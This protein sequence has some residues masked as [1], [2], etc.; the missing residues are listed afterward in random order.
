[1]RDSIAGALQLKFVMVFLVIFIII[2][3]AGLRFLTAFRV[4]NQI[5]S[6]VEMYQGYC[7]DSSD[8]I[9]NPDKCPANVKAE[10]YARKSGFVKT[11][12]GNIKR[13]YLVEKVETGK[14]EDYYVVS[15][16]IVFGIPFANT[17]FTIRV[18]GQTNG[19]I[20]KNG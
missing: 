11:S 3:S 9:N 14:E 17:G 8:E 15:T 1:M 18:K 13:L 20:V 5:I 4:K 7:L 6:Y 19:I 16:D 2:I 10:E 12:N